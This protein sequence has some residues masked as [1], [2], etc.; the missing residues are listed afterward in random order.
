MSTLRIFDTLKRRKVDFEPIDPGNVR[1]YRCGPTVYSLIHVGNARPEVA[2]D[3]MYRHLRRRFP[4]VTYVRNITDVDD[5]IIKRA[6]EAGEEPQALAARFTE[7]YRKDVAALGC[8]LPDV[9][10]QVTRHIA[11]IVALIERL[12]DKGVAYATAGGDV[13]FDVS[14]FPHY[15]ELSGQPLDQ[16]EAGARVEV[17]ERKRSPLDFALWKSARPGEPSW[18]SPWGAGRPGWHIECSAMAMRYLGETFDLH[19]GGVDLIFPH[20]ENERAQSQGACGDGTFARHWLHNGFVNFNDQKIAKSDEKMRRLLE[21]AFVLR[22]LIERHG[23]EAVRYFLLTTQYRNPINFEVIEGESDDLRFPG[24]DEAERQV[25]YGYLTRRRLA[26]TLAAGKP[27]APEGPLAEGADA[28]LPALEESL[29]EDFN[30]A[31]ALAALQQGLTLANRLLD[32]KLAAPKDVKR[33]TL[34]R[35]AGDLATASSLLGV[36]EADPGEWLAAH[37]LRRARARG[38]SAEAVERKIAERAAARAAK[39]FARSDGLRDEL[40]AG[41]V[42]LM[43]G[44]SGTSWRVAD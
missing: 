10:P 33:R 21:R 3:V 28:W 38:I 26:E 32:G 16:L 43:D 15:G 39:D 42:E 36:L 8:L 34:E 14:R 29:D 40:R 9:E 23:G 37:R 5:K 25:E 41:G 44:P 6:R 4:R 20:H 30:T 22:G 13:W 12:V 2:F 17:D 19:G 35:I 11:E 31:G 24:L 18:Q 27:G 7:E 1:L